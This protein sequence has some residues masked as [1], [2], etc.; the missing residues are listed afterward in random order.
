MA[1]KKSK[2][3]KVKRKT[4]KK[5]IKKSYDE[6]SE[7][8]G[9][10]VPVYAAD[11]TKGGTMAL[12]ESIFGQKPNPTLLAQAVRVYLTNQRTA[13]AK[14]KGRGQVKATTKKIYRQ[15]GTG[16]AR[17]GAK[18]A[19]IYVGGGIAHGPTGIV[20]RLSIS[21]RMRKAA[22][23]Q[24]LS[25]KVKEGKFMVADIENTPPKTKKV[26]LFLDK[27]GLEKATILYAGGK[28]LYRAA[29]NIPGVSLVPAL[30]ASTY[31]ILFS[32]SVLSTK[33][34]VQAIKSRFEKEK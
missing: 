7:T 9:L 22:F 11:G 10:M 24:A 26:A 25:S 12:P 17:H 5:I 33:E 20:P 16:G 19:P 14:T 30:Q 18:S 31:H 29:R 28:N 4:T 3:Q 21:Q 1:A 6:T 32:D 27:L 15:K 13:G 2:T 8:T 34:G 23:A